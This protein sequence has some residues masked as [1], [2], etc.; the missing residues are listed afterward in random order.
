MNNYCTI[1]VAK[2]KVMVRCAVTAQ[3]I[4][5]FVF[6]YYAKIRFSHDVAHI[7]FS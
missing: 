3:L 4:F 2:T 1:R 6:A 7:T 5:A